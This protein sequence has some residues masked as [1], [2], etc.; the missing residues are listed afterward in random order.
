M[1][2]ILIAEEARGENIY[3][4]LSFPQGVPHSKEEKFH[5]Q[6]KWTFQL[7]LIYSASC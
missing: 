7:W 5:R 2:H 6:V 3:L 4:L 1:Q